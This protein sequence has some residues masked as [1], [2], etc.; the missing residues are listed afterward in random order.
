MSIE[1]LSQDSDKAHGRILYVYELKQ[2]TFFSA[3]NGFRGN[4]DAER[5]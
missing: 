4:L 2:L 3:T 1:V 5:F